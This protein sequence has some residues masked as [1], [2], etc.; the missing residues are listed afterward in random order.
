MQYRNIV[1]VGGFSVFVQGCNAISGPNCTASVEP[2]V[3]VEI[4]D[5]RTGAGIAADARGIVRDGTYADSL[6]PYQAA[7][8]DPN[9]LFSRRAAD[10]RAGTYVVEVQHP[11]YVKW[12]AAGI[13][14]SENACHVE[15]QRVTASL[16]PVVVNSAGQARPQVSRGVS[17]Q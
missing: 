9:T 17:S 10:E 2:A 16:Q 7:S 15:T 12:T 11:A 1:Y 6:A 3:V 14:V 5:A 8:S 4:R 13:R